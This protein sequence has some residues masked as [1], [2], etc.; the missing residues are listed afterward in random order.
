MNDFINIETNRLSIRILEL[1]D[2][3]AFFNYRNMPEVYQFQSWE[4]S[5]I[6]KVEEFIIRNLAVDPTSKNSWLQLGIYLKKDPLIGDMGLHFL[7]DGAQMEIGYTLAP[8]YQGQGYASEAVKAVIDY[9]FLVS[10]KHRITAS[11]DP[12]NRKSINLLKK[13][14][15]RQEAHFIKSYLIRGEW[16]DDIVYAMLEEE[17]VSKR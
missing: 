17:W 12:E 6:D 4:P 7:E 8:V 16:C 2:K 11:V 14:G 15:F 13:L 10:K 5:S 9:L 3:E 1:K